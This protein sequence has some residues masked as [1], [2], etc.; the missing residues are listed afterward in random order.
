MEAGPGLAC[1][2][3]ESGHLYTLP[4][5]GGKQSPHCRQEKTEAQAQ[6]GIRGGPCFPGWLRGLCG[7]DAVV[8]STSLPGTAGAPVPSSPAEPPHRGASSAH[9]SPPLHASAPDFILPA[10]PGPGGLSWG[11]GTVM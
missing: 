1:L 10:V 11:L 7:W 5:P 3:E 9:L 6:M 8:T 4:S 2:P